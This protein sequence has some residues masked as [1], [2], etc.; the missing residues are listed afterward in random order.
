MP[1]SQVAFKMPRDFNYNVGGKRFYPRETFSESLLLPA[2][3]EIAICL[4]TLHQLMRSSGMIIINYLYHDILYFHIHDPRHHAHYHYREYYDESRQET[5]ALYLQEFF[6][7]KI[8]YSHISIPFK[9]LHIKPIVEFKAN[10]NEKD[11][12]HS[13]QHYDFMGH[14]VNTYAHNHYL[15][16]CLNVVTRRYYGRDPL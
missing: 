3:Y 16:H 11:C 2:K 12:N 10:G 9:H 15:A 5:V 8:L 14:F 4:D 1:K 13:N 6:F 7:Q